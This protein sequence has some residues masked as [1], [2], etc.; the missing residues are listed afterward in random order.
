MKSLTIARSIKSHPII[1]SDRSK[2]VPGPCSMQFK[3]RACSIRATKRAFTRRLR[4][5]KTTFQCP[6]LMQSRKASDSIIE[7]CRERMSRIWTRQGTFSASSYT[8]RSGLI[9]VRSLITNTPQ[10]LTQHLEA[11][12]VSFSSLKS[13]QRSLRSSPRQ[14]TR[15]GSS[16]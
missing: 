9:K 7:V 1:Q 16:T 14:E 13:P 5:R 3:E 2:A 12:A 6:R 8:P 4:L 15:A 10:A 11:R